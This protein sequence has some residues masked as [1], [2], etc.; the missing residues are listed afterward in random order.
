MA[1]LS[2]LRTCPKKQKHLCIYYT[3]KKKTTTLNFIYTEVIN[4]SLWNRNSMS[5]ASVPSTTDVVHWL[6]ENIYTQMN[7]KEL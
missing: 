2:F 5:L 7:L 6:I 1:A 4:T 3:T